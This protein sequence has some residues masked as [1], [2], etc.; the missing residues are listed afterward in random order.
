M[1]QHISERIRVSLLTGFLFL[2]TAPLGAHTPPKHAKLFFIGLANDSVVES[3]FKV[4]MGIRGFGI[5]PA[6]T[7]GIRRHQGGHHH[8][9]IDVEQLPDMDAPIP[10]DA[11]H[12]HYDRGETEA[13][14]N[15]PP[16]RHTLQLL[17]GDEDH[18]PQNPPLLSEIITITVR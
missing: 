15:L 3:P 18:E 12:L 1:K 9:L 11:H 4:R 2:A 17:L 10:A 14:L 8:L 6:G 13:V 16:G 7:T 5:T